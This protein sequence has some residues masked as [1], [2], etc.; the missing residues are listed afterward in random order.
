MDQRN[1]LVAVDG[2]EQSF[3][4]VRYVGQLLPSGRTKFTILH[5]QDQIPE[6]YWDLEDNPKVHNKVVGIRIWESH[7]TKMMEDFMEKARQSLKDMG[8][9]GDAV[10][11]QIR[12]RQVGVAR[13]IVAEVKN[14]Y[15]ALV[16]GRQGL[17]KLKD[18]IMGSIANK[19][20]NRLVNVPLW[21]VGGAPSPEK[22]LVTTGGSERIMRNFNYVIDIFGAKHPDI[23]VFHAIR[24]LKSFNS[25]TG[26]SLGTEDADWLKDVNAEFLKSKTEIEAAVQKGILDMESRGADKTRIKTKIVLEVQSRAEAIV[27]EAKNN[28]YGTIVTGRK[29]LSK[30]EELFVGRVSSKI[31]QMAKE[32]AVWVV[33]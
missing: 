18:L 21:V 27:D 6:S 10:S 22:I 12:K 25:Y 24:G 15:Q 7:Q 32:Q 13:D 26:P 14:G 17:S 9:P 31:I 19:L 16:V 4:I 20:V 29:S 11:T 2:S 23:L 3:E 5:I 1:I 33:N 30:L 28:G 8:H